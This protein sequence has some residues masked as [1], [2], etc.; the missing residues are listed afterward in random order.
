ML[1]PNLFKKREARLCGRPTTTICIDM[2]AGL[3]RRPSVVYMGNSGEGGGGGD[4]VQCQRRGSRPRS[5]GILYTSRKPDDAGGPLL[6]LRR[7]ACRS[8]SEAWL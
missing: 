3:C 5:G 6:E 1:E 7:H 8:R 2:E 4:A